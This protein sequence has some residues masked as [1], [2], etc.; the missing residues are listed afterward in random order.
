MKTKS[1]LRS[2]PSLMLI[3]SVLLLIGSYRLMFYQGGMNAEP[4][5]RQLENH[6]G[7]MLLIFFGICVMTWKL[8]RTFYSPGVPMGS[9][10]DTIADDDLVPAMDS[11]Q[12]PKLDHPNR[13]NS[14][15]QPLTARANFGAN[16]FTHAQPT[17]RQHATHNQNSRLPNRLGLEETLSAMSVDKQ[18]AVFAIHLKEME[19]LQ[20]GL[21]SRL[22]DDMLFSVALRLCGQRQGQEILGQAHSSKFVLIVPNIYNAQQAVERA[23]KLQI[24]F[25]RPFDVHSSSLRVNICIGMALG[26]VAEYTTLVD[27]AQAAAS[28]AAL[29]PSPGY[30]LFDDSEHTR[31]KQRLAL[32]QRIPS[33]LLNNEFYME[34]QP[35]VS[36]VSGKIVSFEALLRW[37]DHRG[38]DI[39]TSDFI[40]LAEKSGSIIELGEFALLRACAEML[41][42]EVT[43]RWPGASVSINVSARQLTNH[44]LSELVMDVIKLGFPVSRLGLEITESVMMDVPEVALEQCRQLARL[45]AALYLDDF[46]TGYSSLKYLNSMPLTYLKIDQSFVQRMTQNKSTYNIVQHLHIMTHSL[47]ME[48]IAEGVETDEQRDVLSKLGC[49][50]LQGY[51][52]SKPRPIADL[53]A[54]ISLQ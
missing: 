31:L 33:G 53:L 41:N 47:G 15:P 44:R 28:R 4:L 49:D 50:R 11:K 1:F 46:G 43:R 34:Y 3:V 40:P 26:R 51:L 27:N 35:V 24:E 7:M 32:E 39:S 48:I 42:P 22:T 37:R 8:Y 14:R 45:G 21:G 9:C 10:I 38:T 17:F 52:I 5:I 16:Q 18:I 30:A 25:D 23:H 13:P 19:S 20:I 6:M 36:A 12:P 2:A 54:D 29:R